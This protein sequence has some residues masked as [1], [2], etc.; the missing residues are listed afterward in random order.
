MLGP[1]CNSS[2]GFVSVFDPPTMWPKSNAEAGPS[3]V[4]QWQ[5]MMIRVLDRQHTISCTTVRREDALPK[6]TTCCRPQDLPTHS[7]GRSLHR[8]ATIE[9]CNDRT[10]RSPSRGGGLLWYVTTTP[11][12]WVH[13][14][15]SSRYKER[16]LEPASL[17][18]IVPGQLDRGFIKNSAPSLPPRC[19]RSLAALIG[20]DQRV[21]GFDFPLQKRQL[22]DS[23]ASD[24]YP[25][26]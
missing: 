25:P 10:Q 20:T 7:T 13:R 23:V 17:N 1:N 14:H 8:H 24:R 5:Q 19:T 12:A 26:L 11:A 2:P 18:A 6:S 16:R 3:H 21:R 22:A 4:C 15:G 9:H